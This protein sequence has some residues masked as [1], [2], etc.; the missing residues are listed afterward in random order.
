MIDNPDTVASG[1]PPQSLA[2]DDL[3]RCSHRAIAFSLREVFKILPAALVGRG[4]WLFE[5]TSMAGTA[6]AGSLGLISI[7]MYAENIALTRKLTVGVQ[8][9]GALSHLSVR[10][11][12]A[13]QTPR[14]ARPVEHR[15]R[16]LRRT[17]EPGHLR[18]THAQPRRRPK[19]QRA[20]VHRMD[21]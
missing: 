21:S 9:P 19:I 15:E 3:L 6:K 1:Q 7:N 18:T 20:S 12:S 10:H 13:P 5:M 11:V 16:V 4:S 17:T 8:N 2:L 14:E